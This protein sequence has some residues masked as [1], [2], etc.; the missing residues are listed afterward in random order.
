PSLLYWTV[1]TTTGRLRAIGLS[2]SD[3]PTADV[4]A[5]LEESG[6]QIAAPAPLSAG[7]SARAS[8][9]APSMGNNQICAL[10]PPRAATHANHRPHRRRASVEQFGDRG[11]A[12]A[13]AVGGPQAAVLQ[14]ERLGDV[15]LVVAVAGR[16]VARQ[17]EPRQGRES[18]IGGPS[19]TGLQHAAAPHRYG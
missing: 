12:D 1:E 16:R 18:H 13:G 17:R 10:P 8:P 4:N 6:D 9:P 7:V 5:T 14:H 2:S 19:D 3:P 11:G 15:F